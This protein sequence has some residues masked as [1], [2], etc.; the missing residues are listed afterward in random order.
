[1]CVN[2]NVQQWVMAAALILITACSPGDEHISGY[3]DVASGVSYAEVE[4]L[5]YAN[6]HIKI[7]YGSDPLQ[8]GLLWL[9]QQQTNARAGSTDSND[10]NDIT[11]S[12]DSTDSKKA[13]LIALVHGGCWLNAYDIQHTF[14]LST[15]LAQAGYAVWSLE[16]RRTGDEGGGWPG[17]L[18]D[19]EAGLAAISG[20]EQYPLDT[21]RV[22]V[23]GHSAGGHLALLVA[24]SVSAVAAVIGLAAITDIVAYAEGDGFCE[25]AAVQFMG[26]EL[27]ENTG[28][29]Q[30]ASPAARAKL[31]PP[32]TDIW[33]LHGTADITV[34]LSQATL[35]GATRVT[36]DQGGHFDWVHPG[37]ESF[38]VL[39]LTLQEVLA[40]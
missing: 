6:P 28:L 37:T 38:K 7:G 2:A 22:V 40:Q 10:S 14:A 8:Y 19:V 18:A 39:L 30:A 9:P 5:P 35:P 21:S 24:D 12:T 32:Q 27:S 20:L 26:V 25:K 23:L 17:T 31:S 33:L 29:Y 15:A 11:D 36:V 34:P 1:M 4:V 16:Y 3:S 13:P